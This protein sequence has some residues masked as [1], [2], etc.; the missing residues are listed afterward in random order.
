M[1][2]DR[3]RKLARVAPA[4]LGIVR[5]RELP[6][7]P[8]VLWMTGC[9]QI[10]TDST[11]GSGG[12]TAPAAPAPGT[13]TA[14]AAPSGTNCAQDPT[15]QAILCEQIDTCPGVDVEPGAFPNCGFR[16]YGA[17]ALDSRVRLRHLP[18]SGGRPDDVRTSPSASR[19]ANV[20]HRLPAAGGGSVC[21]FRVPRCGRQHVRHGLPRRM[22]RSSD[23]PSTLRV[24]TGDSG[25]PTG[26]ITISSFSAKSMLATQVRQKDSVFYFAAYPAEDLLDRVRFISA[27][28]RRVSGASP[29]KRWTRATRSLASSAR[30]S[31]PTPRFSASCHG[32]KSAQSRISTR[33]R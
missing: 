7:L 19:R 27:S 21:R 11:N 26:E 16:V 13:S 12:S 10:G 32:R 31:G 8:F 15:T 1:G 17:A 22:R 20:A 5:M 28:T 2:R 14:A 29:P 3:S 33:R 4:A 24:L 23:L 9:L 25:E 30:S 6:L 18:L